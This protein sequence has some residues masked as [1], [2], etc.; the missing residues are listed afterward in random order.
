[1][2]FASFWQGVLI[3]GLVAEGRIPA[4]LT[5]SVDE[6]ADG[7]QVHTQSDHSDQQST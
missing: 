2:V 7:L 6:V 5:Y 4:T 1:M 3:S